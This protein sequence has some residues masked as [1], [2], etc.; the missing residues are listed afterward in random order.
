M[1]ANQSDLKPSLAPELTKAE[2]MR[3]YC[4][5]NLRKKKLNT[6]AQFYQILTGVYAH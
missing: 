5:G 3:D 4:Q 1:L 2:A 6:Y